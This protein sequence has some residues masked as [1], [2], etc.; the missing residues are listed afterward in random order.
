MCSSDKIFVSGEENVAS[1]RSNFK[2]RD[3]LFSG[4]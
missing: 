3:D 1:G 4:S 2:I